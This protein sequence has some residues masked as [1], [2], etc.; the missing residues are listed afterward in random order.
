ETDRPK[1]APIVFL[2][3]EY[4]YKQIS[5]A[6]ASSAC[7][8]PSGQGPLFA[9]SMSGHGATATGDLL[10]S[11]SMTSAASTPSGQHLGPMNLLEDHV[12][13]TDPHHPAT[14]ST[15]G[16]AFATS[17]LAAAEA[18]SGTGV[19]NIMKLQ[20]DQFTHIILDEAHERDEKLEQLFGFLRIHLSRPRYA[21]IKLMLMSATPNL[22]A[23]LQYFEP[24]GFHSFG[25]TK[26]GRRKA[27]H[28][29]TSNRQDDPAVNHGVEAASV[30]TAE[31][32]PPVNSATENETQN[33]EEAI[34]DGRSVATKQSDGA[35]VLP[36]EGEREIPIK[37]ENDPKDRRVLCVEGR[38]PFPVVTRDFESETLRALEEMTDI[39][40]RNKQ[41][42]SQ[43]P[44]V[45]QVGATRFPAS[46][47]SPPWHLM[48]EARKFVSLL[49]RTRSRELQCKTPGTTSAIPTDF[50]YTS[51]NDFDFSHVP[52][53]LRL[54]LA[55]NGPVFRD[56]RILETVQREGAKLL[57]FLPGD[58]ETRDC[59]AKMQR[60][61]ARAVGSTTANISS[62][63]GSATTST[64]RAKK[65]K[66]SKTIDV[67]SLKEELEGV[68]KFDHVRI[69]QIH[70]ML[71]G[72]DNELA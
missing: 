63:T 14:T 29:S 11:V 15:G 39:R 26:R 2:T 54:L 35:P 60:V 7:N 58:P 71:P 24:L 66:T 17:T 51:Y 65:K 59:F 48:E 42:P 40:W 23:L 28:S 37:P 38:T 67:P 22:E 50:T 46:S 31:V 68:L 27:K 13:P 3:P 36:E 12:A 49:R 70:G 47:P 55:S 8:L 43:E 20:L 72:A 33:E 10:P 61:R 6:P 32:G 52:F 19:S 44:G 57:V 1:I 25:G 45:V 62:A 4:F 5:T 16:A 64:T 30:D 21:A 18:N 41:P 9:E 34:D 56:T 53:V 69:D